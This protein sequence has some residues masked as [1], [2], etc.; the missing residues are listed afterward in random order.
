MSQWAILIT[1]VLTFCCMS[2]TAQQNFLQRYQARVAASLAEQPHWPTPLVTPT[3]RLD[4]D[5]K[6]DFAR[7]RNSAGFDTWNLGNSRG[8][9]LLPL[10]PIQL[11]FNLPPF[12]DHTAPNQKDGFGDVTFTLRYRLL[13]RNEPKGNRLLTAFLGASVPTGKNGNGSCC[14]VMTPGVGGGKGWGRTAI[15]G[16]T[17][18]SLPVSNVHSLGHMVTLHGTAEYTLA[19]SG[20]LRRVTPQLETNTSFFVG[21]DKDGKSQSYLTPG[22]IVGRFPFSRKAAPADS[23]SHG[24]TF[25]IGEQIAVSSYHSYNHALILAFRLP[26]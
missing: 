22:F 16:Y 3:P 15:L 7:Q 17:G 25:A 1:S 10:R 4:Q 8:L 23:V 9:D 19:S 21:G 12:L 24:V 20:W 13:S 2:A 18:V 11:S 6:W 5:I 14:A 26:I